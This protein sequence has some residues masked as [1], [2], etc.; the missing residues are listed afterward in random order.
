VF[1]SNTNNS[2]LAELKQ[3][4][5]NELSKNHHLNAQ[6]EVPKPFLLLREMIIRERYYRALPIMTWTEW[7]SFAYLSGIETEDQLEAATTFLAEFGYVMHFRHEPQ[8]PGGAELRPLGQLIVIHPQW[9]ANFM[10]SFQLIRSKYGPAG[11]ISA[12]TLQGLLKLPHIWQVPPSLLLTLYCHLE[13]AFL[14][15]AVPSTSN[16]ALAQGSAEVI[17]PIL[18]PN[19]PAD[20]HPSFL[21]LAGGQSKKPNKQKGAPKEE[22]LCGRFYFV[23][24][25]VD[26]FFARV[27]SRLASASIKI[28]S[29]SRNSFLFDFGQ[30]R[31]F[32]EHF[33]AEGFI[34]ARVRPLGSSEAQP[35]E[36]VAENAFDLIDTTVELVLRDWSYTGMSV[37]PMVPCGGCLQGAID[38]NDIHLFPLY[39]LYQAAIENPTS[40]VLSCPRSSSHAGEGDKVEVTALLPHVPICAQLESR[41][42][43]LKPSVYSMNSA[44]P[45]FKLL[46]G[47]AKKGFPMMVE[48]LRL[49]TLEEERGIVY[50]AVVDVFM[51]MNNIEPLLRTAFSVEINSCPK[52][53]SALLF[54]DE[55]GAIRLLNAYMK[56][57]GDG[58]LRHAIRPLL[59]HLMSFPFPLEIDAQ[60][61]EDATKTQE[62]VEKLIRIAQLFVD[63]VCN[64]TQDFPIELRRI[65]SFVSEKVAA[66]FPDMRLLSIG[67]LLFLRFLNPAILTPNPGLPD[68]ERHTRRSA[69][70]VVK[71]LNNLMNEVSF[72]GMKEAYMLPL[73]P[74]ISSDN[75]QKIQKFITDLITLAKPSDEF[76]FSI[77]RGLVA[78]EVVEQAP[79]HFTQFLASID[80]IKKSAIAHLA[81]LSE[82]N[83]DIRTLA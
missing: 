77:S 53:S 4:L 75:I 62:N 16:K 42:S 54:R 12:T 29:F 71:L 52:D 73:N 30:E 80:V 35:T 45:T 38:L 31:V 83:S 64:S 3:L 23:Y 70:L 44:L 74:F 11:M 33:L 57:L 34:T 10:S 17:L 81:Q 13:L 48:L 41:A 15:L 50:S 7:K 78:E 6:S 19:R 1:V 36:G 58:F 46:L 55:S 37:Q 56:R 59:Q 49:H 82:L 65:L 2:G 79:N 40:P 26:G 9:F 69:M 21:P 72:D 68:M 28:I 43:G 32:L 8:I 61:M 24:H 27:I 76:N 5:E 51:K 66:K 22:G 47:D 39:A 14:R 25:L 18:L 63:H 20:P 67:N 60:R